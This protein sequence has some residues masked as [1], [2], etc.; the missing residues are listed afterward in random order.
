MGYTLPMTFKACDPDI[1]KVV[2]FTFRL[3]QAVT[4]CDYQTMNTQPIMMQIF[5]RKRW[6]AGAKAATT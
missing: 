4:G 1:R 5:F 2:E 3:A 6:M